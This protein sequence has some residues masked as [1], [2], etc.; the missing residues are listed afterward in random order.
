MR[1]VGPE[2]SEKGTLSW[3]IVHGVRVEKGIF[4]EWW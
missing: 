1:M 2:S 4:G 3:R